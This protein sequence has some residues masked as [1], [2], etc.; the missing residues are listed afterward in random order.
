MGCSTTEITEFE[1]KPQKRPI[2]VSSS[3]GN[4]IQEKRT[5]FGKYLEF[6]KDYNNVFYF[7]FEEEGS[8]FVQV[9]YHRLNHYHL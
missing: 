7:T 5:E 6:T 1:N 4:E 9:D 8:F 3:T 2:P